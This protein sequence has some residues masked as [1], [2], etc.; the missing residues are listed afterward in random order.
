LDGISA[1]TIVEALPFPAAIIDPSLRIIEA[2][3]QMSEI[4]DGVSVGRH[5]ALIVR[6][7]DVLNAVEAALRG[8]TPA[9]CE[10]DLTDGRRRRTVWATARSLG[11]G[12]GALLVFQDKTELFE[13]GRMRTDFVAKGS[14]EL[15]TPLTAMSGI[16]ET[17]KGAAGDDPAAQARF[18]DIIGEEVARMNRLVADLL[19]LARVESG[20]MAERSPAD[21]RKLVAQSIELLSGRA[22]ELGVAITL[23]APDAPVMALVDQDLLRHVF[24]N[25]IENAVKYGRSGRK[26]EITIEASE[27]TTLPQGRAVAVRVRDH[28]EGIEPRHLSRLTERFYR[29]DKHRSRGMGGTGLGLAIVKHA[30]ERHRGRLLIESTPG[31]GS[32]FTALLPVA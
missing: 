1:K 13:I 24:N 18:L 4:I 26:V 32:L 12:K 11:T 19:S 14:H 25:L 21:I 30:I 7:P 8:E 27:E 17:L 22:A 23:S 3:Q 28:G 15:R 29:I 16:V 5:L 9:D 20:Q 10:F 2:S 6:A 31:E